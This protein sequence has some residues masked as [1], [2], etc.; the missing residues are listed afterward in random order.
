MPEYKLILLTF[1]MAALNIGLLLKPEYC[2]FLTIIFSQSSLSIPSLP[3]PISYIEIFYMVGFTFLLAIL[4]SNAVSGRLF[5][6]EQGYYGY[7]YGLILVIIITMLFR[8]FGLNIAGTMQAGGKTYLT[9]LLSLG[10]ILGSGSIGLSAGQWRAALIFM[11]CLGMIFLDI[12][13]PIDGGTG[14]FDYFSLKNEGARFIYGGSIGIS[15]LLLFYILS[16]GKNMNTLIKYLMLIA[17]FILIG[18]SG[19]R[20]AFITAVLFIGIFNLIRNRDR[21]GKVKFM[22]R[23]FILFIALI[24]VLSAVVP[25]LPV[26]FQRGLT[27]LPFVKVSSLAKAQAQQ[28]IKWRVDIW[29]SVLPDVPRYL[30]IGKGCAFNREEFL[31]LMDTRGGASLEKLMLTGSYHNGPLGLIIKFGAISL[32]LLLGLWFV[33]CRKHMRLAQGEWHDQRIKGYHRV[34]LAYFITR[35]LTFI[36]IFGSVDMLPRLLFLI[37]ILEQLV[38]SDLKSKAREGLPTRLLNT[39]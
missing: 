3:A 29:R 26:S 39:G 10:L 33:S 36:F 9:M 5:R 32:I 34:M 17:S 14:F 15:L 16:V 2:A 21:S 8:G 28:T 24:V 25:Y 23:A 31:Y 1:F 27:W 30:W 6:C 22:L 19:H 20:I 4:I 12:N 7:V 18:M 11:C 35:C 13:N 38:S 37:V